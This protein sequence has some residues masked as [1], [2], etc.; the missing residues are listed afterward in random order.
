MSL[1]LFLFLFLIALCGVVVLSYEAGKR[2]PVLGRIFEEPEGL[3]LLGLA[4]LMLF[5]IVLGAIGIEIKLI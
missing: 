1:I 4:V 2:W 5:A 3:F